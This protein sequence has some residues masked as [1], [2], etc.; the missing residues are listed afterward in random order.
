MI[1]KQESFNLLDGTTIPWLAWGSGTGQSVKKA[2]ECGK[3]ALTSGIRHLDTAQIY[4]TES[5]TG[6][7]IRESEV[8]REEVYV[9]SKSQYE[10]REN[11]V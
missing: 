6:E 11:T 5:Q 9:T 3:L 4:G 7:V 1:P 10:P 2:L 8:P